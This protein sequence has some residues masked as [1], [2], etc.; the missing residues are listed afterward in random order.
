MF[1]PETR[2]P[3]IPGHQDVDDDEADGEDGQHAPHGYGHQHLHLTVLVDQ[4]LQGVRL[5]AQT[6]LDVYLVV[7]A[8]L[9]VRCLDEQSGDVAAVVG[10][11][12]VQLVSAV[13]SCPAA[14]FWPELVAVPL[15]PRVC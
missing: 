13:S 2:A 14:R 15:P 11:E 3:V 5:L 7:L 6:I 10:G 4:E 1:G 12:L 8:V 9:G